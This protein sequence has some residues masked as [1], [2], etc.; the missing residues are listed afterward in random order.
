[1][2]VLDFI[3]NA[4][5]LLLWLNWRSRGLG[6]LPSRPPALALVGTLRRAGPRPRERWSSPLVLV[7]VLLL[8]SFLYSQLGTNVRWL[9][10][11]S[12]PGFVIHFRPD[13]FGRMLV[14]SLLSFGLMLGAFYFSLMLISALNGRK[15]NQ[16]PWTVLVNAHLGFLGC[17][18]AWTALVLPFLMAFLFWLAVG[19][20]L[21]LIQ[22]HA[23]I[24][25]AG[26]LLAEAAVVGIGGWLLW[27]YVLVLLLGLHL[28]S[29]Y[30]Y[31]G[32]APFWKFIDITTANLLRPIA[33]LPLR[34][35][36]VDFAPVIALTVLVVAAI[37]APRLLGVIYRMI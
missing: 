18:P 24:P 33:W 12:F 6:T 20:L 19:P 11:L 16:D 37:Y 34:I 36:R 15:A 31:F 32:N 35:G 7:S 23:P 21:A 4:V 17:L 5:C 28:L 8:R 10:Q 22:V 29:S 1:M 26:R 13:V 30:V 27:K 3:L 25:S 9:P 2:A 14:Y